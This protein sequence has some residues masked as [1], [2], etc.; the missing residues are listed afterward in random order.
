MRPHKGASP[1]HQHAIERCRVSAVLDD[2]ALGVS[3]MTYISHP[4]PAST[5]PTRRSPRAALS[6]LSI[7]LGI[8]SRTAKLAILP[9]TM[10]WREFYFGGLL[11]IQLDSSRDDTGMSLK[12]YVSPPSPP[13]LLGPC[14]RASALLPSKPVRLTSTSLLFLLN[15]SPEHGNWLVGHPHGPLLF[16]WC[17]VR[18]YGG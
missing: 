10:P 12:Y 1:K 2:R 9:S 5:T 8:V 18:P 17:R 13:S 4:N 14:P 16:Y 6:I 15:R 3:G 7:Q 11:T